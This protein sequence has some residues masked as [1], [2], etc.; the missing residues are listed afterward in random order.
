M[1]PVTHADQA[2]CARPEWLGRTLKLR[3]KA[4]GITQEGLAAKTGISAKLISA[5]ENDRV[6]PRRENRLRLC[7][8]LRV[9]D[10]DLADAA[11]SQSIPSGAPPEAGDASTAAAVELRCVLHGDTARLVG[12]RDARVLVTWSEDDGSVSAIAAAP[13]GRLLKIRASVTPAS[14][15]DLVSLR[16]LVDRLA[17]LTQGTGG[18]PL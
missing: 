13:D 11:L 6:E 8:A 2:S 3:R 12:S 16:A 7:E 18:A 9:D 5:Y 4:L 14:L 17:E 10:P 1:A 15:D